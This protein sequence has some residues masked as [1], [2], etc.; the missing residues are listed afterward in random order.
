MILL[1]VIGLLVVLYYAVQLFFWTVLDCDI[2]LFL[3]SFLG[4]P[5]SE[6]I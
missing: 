2:E 3:A 5:I 4:R 1:T 6:F